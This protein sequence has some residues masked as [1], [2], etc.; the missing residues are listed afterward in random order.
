[1]SQSDLFDPMPKASSLANI[2]AAWDAWL[3]SEKQ[4][5]RLHLDSSVSVYAAIWRAL[6]MWCVSQKYDLQSLDT[7]GLERFLA[8]R[9]AHDDISTRHAWRVLRLVDRV[10]RH[11]AKVSGLQPNR[12]AAVLLE[13]RPDYRLANAASKDPLPEFL[14]ASEAKI[15]V[16]YLSAV[17]PA[18]AAAGA[19]LWQDVRNRCSVALML[20]AGVTPGEVRALRLADA[21]STGGRKAGVPW[22]LRVGGHSTTAGRETPL[23]PWAGQLLGYWLKVRAEQAIPGDVLLP[24]TRTGKPW[25]KVS[26]YNATA[27]V[28]T[29]AGIDDVAGGSFRLRHTF[30]VRQLKKGHSAEDVGRWLG[31]TD[32]AV[33][34]RY[35]RV[36][37][38]P[39]DVI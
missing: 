15:L 9:G 33:M 26:Q 16:T 4:A 20:G 38:S 36:L 1:M 28:L 34:T 6:A 30:A 7:A 31:V 13:M 3:A 12:A 10:M 39:A 21:V 2:E 27:E 5:G 14:L 11:H 17:R 25:S 8:S 29:D 22:K 18:R 23:A 35:A 24:S 37:S 32:P 19:A